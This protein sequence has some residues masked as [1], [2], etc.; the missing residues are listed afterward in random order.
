MKNDLPVSTDSK[1]SKQETYSSVYKD[2]YQQK[3]ANEINPPE[4]NPYRLA[5]I[6]W[7][8]LLIGFLLPPIG[9]FIWILGKQGHPQEAKYAGIGTILGVLAIVVWRVIGLSYQIY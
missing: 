4:V 1:E 8:C 9:F 2:I 6:S 5:M 7:L 3:K